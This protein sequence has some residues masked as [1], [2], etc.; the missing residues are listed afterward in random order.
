MRRVFI[1]IGFFIT[2]FWLRSAAEYR[3]VR[4]VP[5]RATLLTV[6]DLGNAYVVREG[7]ALVKF[8]E[9]GDSLAF[10]RSVEN[11]PVGQVD[12]SN[13]L[14]VVV[15]FPQYARVVL[16][17]RMLAQKNDLDLRRRNF[18]NAAAVAASA[19][20]NL[21]IYD[22]FNA[23]LRKIDEQLEEV[24]QSNDIR[25]EVQAVP[26]ASFLLERDRKVFLT[27]TAKGIFTFDRFGNYI[28]TLSI[29]GIRKLQV[30]GSQLIY[31]RGDSLVSWDLDRII[32]KLI[33]IP[34]IGVPVIDAF[35]VRQT[36]YVLYADRLS[37]YQIE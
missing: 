15:W 33:P 5:M 23:R 2:F 12:A 25:Q 34:K 11:G 22:Q 4:S 7:N 10:F 14:R 27:D 35:I 18:Q 3:L 29:P 9:H 21:W 31:R 20:G 1:L 30:A 24:A 37:L 13:P 19:D 28:N 16:L 6:D 17:D 36:L 26:A 32:E 8:D